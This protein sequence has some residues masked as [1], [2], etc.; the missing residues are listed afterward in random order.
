MCLLQV[1]CGHR[2][3]VGGPDVGV[4]IMLR[5]QALDG[6]GAVWGRCTVQ[7]GT[8][9]C[10]WRL[11]K[12]HIFLLQPHRACSYRLISTLADG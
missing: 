10:L 9:M 4:Q 6:Q 5:D 2:L 12:S 8:G 3:E 11:L 7:Y 1:S